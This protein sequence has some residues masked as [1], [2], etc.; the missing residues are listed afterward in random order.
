M[1]TT[2]QGLTERRRSFVI[3]DALGATHR[4]LRSFVFAEAAFLVVCGIT[5]GAALGWALSQM[6]V[7]VP[8]GDFDPPPTG[9]TVPWT[10]LTTTAAAIIVAIGAVSATTVRLARRSPLTGLG[11]L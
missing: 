8:T 4:H 6:L 3:A 10:Y 1:R 11:E 5:A 9:L 2:R 7:S